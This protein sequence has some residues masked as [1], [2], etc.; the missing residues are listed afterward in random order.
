M[1]FEIFDSNIFLGFLTFSVTK[2]VRGSNGTE[3]CGGTSEMITVCSYTLFEI[4]SDFYMFENI[5]ATV[6]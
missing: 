2:N 6:F 3:G 4:A 5:T 1:D